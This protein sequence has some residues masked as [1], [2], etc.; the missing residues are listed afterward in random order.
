MNTTKNFLLRIVCISAICLLSALIAQAQQT[1]TRTLKKEALSPTATH[2]LEISNL[3]VNG[4]PISFDQ[5]F[6]ADDDWLKGLTFDVKNISGKV[7]THFNIGMH[8]H[9][10][11]NNQRAGRPMILHGR[12]TG[13]PNIE[14]TVHVADGEIVHATYDEKQYSIL[15]RMQPIIS[16][17]KIT[18]AEL[19]IDMVVFEDDTA[20]RHGDM[21]R[22][23]QT[24]PTKWLV[25]RE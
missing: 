10:L 2:V 25:I 24:N 6:Q 14:A 17:S 4:A 8:M 21:M 9:N 3:K 19:T 23:D 15:K 22:R 7:I 18:I 5:P 20:W 12:D 11:D 13:L 16:L 1:E